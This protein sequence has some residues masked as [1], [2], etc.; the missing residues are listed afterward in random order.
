MGH[1]IV[2]ARS[3]ATSLSLRG[4]CRLLCHCEELS[5]FFV[6]ARSLPTSLSL[7]G[8]CRLLCHCEELSDFFVIARSLP[9]SLSLRGACRRSNLLV[10]FT[11]KGFAMTIGLSFFDRLP[12]LKPLNDSVLSILYPLF[13]FFNQLIIFSITNAIFLLFTS[14]IT[15]A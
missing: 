5:D 3:L 2:I 4:A 15:S 12:Q 13:L 11:H 7:R 8:A 14:E 1:H 10:Y 6:I 9:T